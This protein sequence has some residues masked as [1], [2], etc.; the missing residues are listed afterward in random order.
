MR[1]RTAL[2]TGAGRGIGR[3]IAV[4]LGESGWTVAVN[5]RSDKASAEACL[6]AVMKAGG[7]GFCVQAD[8]ANLEEHEALIKAV[9]S[10]GR[11]LDLLV[12][13]AGMAPRIREDMLG[14][15]P[16]SYDEVMRTNLRGPFFLTQKAAGAMIET[17][18]S[19]AATAVPMIINITSIS[20]VAA[21]VNR[22]EYCISKA[23]LSMMTK[24]W[25]VRLAEHGIRV[26]EIRP[27]IIETD[28][29]AGVK[30]K[31]DRLFSEGITLIPRW[32]KPEDV[33]KA[34]VA[35]AENK[36]PYSTGEVF[37]LDGGLSVARL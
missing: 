12:N 18:K 14:V 22:A 4:A 2:V 29:T 10:N 21:S 34:V 15:S 9:M 1:R 19:Q 17:V 31:Y 32:G 37:T 11:G 36:F 28:M 30:D 35:L 8:V 20:A 27:G 26:Y 6:E 23:G 25:A 16:E 3:G 33:G 7:D 24:L 13:N 5:Y